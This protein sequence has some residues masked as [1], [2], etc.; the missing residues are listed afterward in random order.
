MRL[1]RGQSEYIRGILGFLDFVRQNSHGAYHSCPCSKC[2]NRNQLPFGEMENH[3][4]R[5]GICRSY[6]SWIYH[7][8]ERPHEAP[9][10]A[11]ELHINVESSSGSNYQ[12]PSVMNILNDA[13]RIPPSAVER[14][15]QD[16]FVRPEADDEAAVT[17]DVLPAPSSIVVDQA[18]EF[19]RYSKLVELVKTPLYP[20]SKHTVLGTMMKQMV[21]KHRRRMSNACFDDNLELLKEVL[22]EGNSCPGSFYEVKTMLRSLGL[23]HVQIH[24]CVNNCILYYKENANL[25]ECLVCNEPRYDMNRRS[26]SVPRKVLRYFPVGPRLQRLYMSSKIAKHMRWH[27]RQGRDE[28]GE[29]LTHPRDGEAWKHF[30]RSFPDFASDCRNVRLGLAA[31]GFSPTGDMSIPYTIWPV[32]LF[33]YNLPPNMCMKKE[34]N[35]LTLLVPGPNSP[36]KCLDVYMRPLVD[37]LK[38]LWVNG[39]ATYD[40]HE[41]DCFRMRA[42]VIWTVSDFPAYGMLSGQQTKG[43]YAC[44]V[45]MDDVNS[46]RHANKTCYLGHRRWL[47]QNHPWRMDAE[48]FDGTQEHMPKPTGRSGDWIADKLGQHSFGVLS[49]CKRVTDFNPP[50]PDE[51]RCWTHHSIFFELPYWSTLLI[52]HCLDVMHIEKNVCDSVLG[53][54]LN[55]KYKNKDTVKA[56]VDLKEMGL[57]KPL[58]L[59][60]SKRGKTYMPQAGY[61]VHSSQKESVF[62]FLGRVKY[63]I[64]YAGNIRRCVRSADNSLAGLKTHDCHVLLQRVFPV[65]IRPYLQAH[66]VD[67]LIALSKFFQRI[68][69]KE[70]SSSDMAALQG[71]IVFILCKLERIFPPTFFDIMV[72]LMIHLPEQ[73]MLTGPVQ[74]T[75]CYPNERCV[76]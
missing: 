67:V 64:G 46:S 14:Y 55:L 52:R 10:E 24:A 19:E 28:D 41:E 29:V 74:Y 21:I 6:T 27:E 42:A 25:T 13:L 38:S 33:P 57:R 18:R 50:I 40:R 61:T 11:P 32:I 47:D 49:S 70:L 8:E 17:D 2:R 44:P 48:A 15:E 51:F 7:G 68:C 56:R 1:G 37:E 69:A 31:D 73:L 62:E 35:F 59:K 39:L 54:V 30:D 3:L 72:H 43:Y 12:D 26:G 63:P 22:P 36:G 5:N 66:V 60:Q 16:N 65:L 75:W 71:D 4:Y 53:T 45:C 9:W 20:G 23:E 76:Y 34:Y 58:W